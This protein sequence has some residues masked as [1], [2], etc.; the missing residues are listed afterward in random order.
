MRVL[1][2][3]MGGVLGTRV[4]QMLEARPDVDEIA[5]CDFV[6]PRR[7]LLRSTFKRIAPDDRDRLTDFVKDF[8]PDTIAHFG[9]YEPDSR[10]PPG[11]AARATEACAIAVLSAAA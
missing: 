10:K 4:A 5:G 2:T 7:R 1:V 8:A 11:E 6:P 3:G 9:I